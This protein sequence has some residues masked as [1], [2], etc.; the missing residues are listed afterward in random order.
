MHLLK[1]SKKDKPKPLVPIISQ[2]KVPGVR[3]MRGRR[4]NSAGEDI[5][6]CGPPKSVPDALAVRAVKEAYAAAAKLPRPEEGGAFD[7]NC[8]KPL[9]GRI[10]LTRPPMIKEEN[11]IALPEAQWKHEPYYF[12][13]RIGDRVTSCG[14]GD[15]VIFAAKSK[16]RP[17]KLGA[18][19]FYIG[20][21]T[22]LIALVEPGDAPV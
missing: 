10:L 5:G 1:H 6:P 4:Y 20:R 2:W 3:R 9:P 15:R 19:R 7:L 22:A 14:V 17:I 12:C 18:G 13:I 11:G 8:F 16:P 21:E